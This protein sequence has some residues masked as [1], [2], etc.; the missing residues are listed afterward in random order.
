MK[1][2]ILLA[3]GSG[4]RLYPLTRS[5]NKHLLPIYDK[6]LIYYPLTTLMLAGVSEILIVSSP[7]DIP[8]LQAVLGDGARWGLSLF[9]ASQESPNGIAEGILIAADFINGQPFALI[10]GDNIFYGRTFSSLLLEAAQ[11]ACER[12]V[13]FT[14][15][16]GDPSA[17]GVIELDPDGSPVELTEKPQRPL[18]NRAVTGLYFYDGRALELAR[19]LRPSRRNE[20]EITDLNQIY[21]QEG[22]LHAIQLGRGFVWFD[23]GTT[24][25]LLLASQFV[26]ILQSRQ[27]TGIAFPEEV[28]YRTGLIDFDAFAALVNDMPNCAYRDYLD[29]L[30][31]EISEGLA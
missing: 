20:L 21:L 15:N 13:V 26:E 14:Y 22:C 2:G 6:P 30:R 9:Y 11:I 31:Q 19:S 23:A 1:K 25:N 8:L 28:A 4:T 27:R 10:L 3:G 16:V 18:S 7:K 17:Y 12:A 24:H 29:T 5:V